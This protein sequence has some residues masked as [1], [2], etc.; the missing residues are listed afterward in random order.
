M[1]HL[2]P[3]QEKLYKRIEQYIRGYVSPE[4]IEAV[5][6][7]VRSSLAK[8]EATIRASRR[9]DAYEELEASQ[10]Y[11]DEL[12]IAEEAMLVERGEDGATATLTIRLVGS[13]P[14]IFT[15][16]LDG[17]E[18]IDGRPYAMPVLVAVNDEKVERDNCFLS[19]QLIYYY[20][21][22]FAV[23]VLTG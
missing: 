16:S 3:T 6:S 17:E 19:S 21:A 13:K 5:M 18:M 12:G 11:L 14:L 10:S 1:T 7:L 15:F 9:D 20:I 2:T 22:R 4:K 23:R 8:D